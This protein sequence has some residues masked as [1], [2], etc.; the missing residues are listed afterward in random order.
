MGT[1]DAGHL[2]MTGTIGEVEEEMI[3]EESESG[4][5]RGEE[6]RIGEENREDEAKR[7]LDE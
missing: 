4:E 1:A 6:W 2:D 5:G 3:G 7:D